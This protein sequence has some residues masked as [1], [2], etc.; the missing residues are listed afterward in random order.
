MPYVPHS[1][2]SIKSKVWFCICLFVMHRALAQTETP[3]ANPVEHAPVADTRANEPVRIFSM[4]LPFRISPIAS[5]HEILFDYHAGNTWN[6]S[7]VLEYPAASEPYVANPWDE[8]Y[9]PSYYQAPHRYQLYSADG[10]I[11]SVTTT[12]TQKTSVHGELYA[13]LN[14]N[15][16]VGGGSF[17]DA[18]VSDRAIEGFDKMIHNE[19]AY[20]IMDGY[21]L[22]E[23]KFTDRDGHS[24]E[25]KPHA[26]YMG[27][28]DVG[29]RYFF[30]IIRSDK[31]KLLWTLSTEAQVGIPLNRAREHLSAGV[32]IGSAITKQVTKKYGITVA[33][34]FAAQH[35]KM[36]RI[37]REQFDFNYADVVTGY[38]F[39]F[40]HNFDFRNHKRF[41]IG[42]EMQGMTAPLS[43][44]ERVQAYLNPEDIGIKTNY[45]PEYW[46]PQHPISLTDQRRSSR[47]L[48][49]GSEYLSLNFSYRF[50]RPD[51]SSTIMFYL[52]DDWTIKDVLPLVSS[53]LNN[54][55]DFGVGIKW[56][57][58]IP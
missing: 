15:M 36:L 41:T 51:R 1:P 47:G 38:R 43:T 37:R 27:T 53:E 3:T 48:I 10:V 35:D 23:M 32:I 5:N 25:V 24:L 45:I 13:S 42:I 46:T 16:L 12:Y 17:I 2:A 20:R 50:G 34:G 11:R 49:S 22:A 8:T 28:M 40:G 4:R 30:D 33:V 55:Q 54:S 31:H 39:L 58:L 26:V 18:A 52:Q 44:K 9:R 29:Y 57:R 7:G 6:P 21:N 56:I 19:N 14:A